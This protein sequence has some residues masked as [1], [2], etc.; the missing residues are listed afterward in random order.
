MV[1]QDIKVIDDPCVT[2]ISRGKKKNVKE[3]VPFEASI[4]PLAKTI[5]KEKKTIGYF[6]LSPTYEIQNKI[7][8]N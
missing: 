1:L 5:A 6:P 2:Q 3:K 8:G 4:I 7:V